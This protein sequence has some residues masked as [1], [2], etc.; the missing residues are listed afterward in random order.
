LRIAFLVVR[1]PAASEP[2]ILSQVTGLLDR[3]HEVRIFASEP[4]TAFDDQPDAD[5]Y[6]L[7]ER[8]TY[9]P[10]A[11]ASRAA[12]LVGGLGLAARGALLSPVAVLRSLNPFASGRNSPPLELLRSVFPHLR[13][14]AHDVVHCHYGPNGLLGALLRRW[15][16]IEGKLVVSLHGFDMSRLVRE[17]GERV[18]DDLFREADALLPVSRRWRARLIEM[19][20]P[21][22][23]V[24]VHPMGI[25]LRSFP[26]RP[27][28]LAPGEPVRFVTVARLV[29]K[30]GVEYALRALARL[31]EGGLA[32]EYVVVGDGP[33]RAALEELARSEPLRGAVRFTGPV[34][35]AQV[36]RILDGAHVMLAPSVTASDGDEEGIPVSIMEAMA[37]GLPVVATR[38]SGIPEL[39]EHGVSGTLVPERDVD[40]LAGAMERMARGPQAWPDL[41]RAGR[42][43]VERRHDAARLNDRLVAGAGLEGMEAGSDGA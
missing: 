5:A 28:S 6:G 17:S 21:E 38:H 41:G 30:K 27:R 22:G 8:T 33:L 1:F 16:L 34:P 37:S 3:G 18:Y 4:G 23:K 11:G 14:S 12:R 32:A 25:D 10:P 39:V 20:C 15:G 43:I 35:S 40:A 26:F 24:L 2:W 7:R 31:I 36:A 42:S 13:G 29:E 19:G 9:C